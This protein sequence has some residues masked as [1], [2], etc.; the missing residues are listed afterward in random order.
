MGR[1]P[2]CGRSLKAPAASGVPAQP[3][4]GVEAEAGTGKE[5]LATNTQGSTGAAGYLLEPA[6][7]PPVGQARKQRR[8]SSVAACAGA[9]RW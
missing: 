2:A 5:R 7:Q 3:K 4:T 9:G 8:I 6:E 1:C